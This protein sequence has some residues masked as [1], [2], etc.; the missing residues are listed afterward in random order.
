MRS[1]EDQLA[2]VVDAA[3]APE[4]IRVAL[5]D[6]LGLMC[7]EEVTSTTQVPGFPQ[8]A[9]D[10]FAVRAVDV[11]GSAGLRR[12]ERRAG[13]ARHHRPV[14][15]DHEVV[16]P[17]HR[18]PAAGRGAGEVPVVGVGRG[19]VRGDHAAPVA[20]GGVDVRGHMR[21]VGGI[22]GHCSEPVSGTDRQLG[23]RRHLHQVDVQVIEDGVVGA[24]GGR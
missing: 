9:V 21:G 2:A 23:V 17:V 12:P 22:G 6:A 5:T 16:H 24:V 3:V 8:A 4:P 7:T 19:R 11:G 15:A 10:G 1:V 14:R 13:V 18:R 20:A